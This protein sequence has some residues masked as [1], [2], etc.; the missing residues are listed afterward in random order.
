M[1]SRFETPGP[2]NNGNS[3]PQTCPTGLNGLAYNPCE[4]R[5]KYRVRYFL[6]KTDASLSASC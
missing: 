5:L 2:N 1:E 6:D 4:S 3:C